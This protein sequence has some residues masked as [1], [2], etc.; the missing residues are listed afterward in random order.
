MNKKYAVLSAVI[1]AGLLIAAAIIILLP[2]FRINAFAEDYIFSVMASEKK[3]GFYGNYDA[4]VDSG[5]EIGNEIFCLMLP[6]G[7]VPDD[8][9]VFSYGE[10][11]FCDFSPV[12]PEMPESLTSIDL[13][14]SYDVKLPEREDLTKAY[15]AL[16]AGGGDTV[17]GSLKS[18][19]LLEISDYSFWDIE[20]ALAFCRLAVLKEIY[21]SGGEALVYEREDVKGIVQISEC[22]MNDSNEPYFSV[23][24][25]F[26]SENDLNS[27]YMISMVV[28]SP[29]KAY[30]VI[31]SVRFR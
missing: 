25:M 6:E 16:G 1:A 12:S 2:R 19:A 22:L 28:D 11:E 10:N 3:G 18:A 21:F 27:P 5:T 31:N 13:N 7:Y 24:F 29:E 15:R 26:F 23:C 4:E 9:F 8:E 20:K 30:G 14:R 17:F